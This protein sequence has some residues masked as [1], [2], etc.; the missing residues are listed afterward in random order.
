M[1][2]LHDGNR[3]HAVF[4]RSDNMLKTHVHVHKPTPTRVDTVSF[5]SWSGRGMLMNNRLRHNGRGHLYL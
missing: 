5:S 2:Y 4:L 3:A 1:K